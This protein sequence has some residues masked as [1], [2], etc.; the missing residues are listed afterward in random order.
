MM[1]NPRRRNEEDEVEH[2]GFGDAQKLARYDVEAGQ[3]VLSPL[4]ACHVFDLHAHTMVRSPV[5]RP[6]IV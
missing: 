5:T 4:V 6:Y 2:L 3:A 1:W